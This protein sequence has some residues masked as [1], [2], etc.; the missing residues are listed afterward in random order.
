MSNKYFDYGT[1]TKPKFKRRKKEPKAKKVR[2]RKA[3]AR[4]GHAT[5]KRRKYNATFDYGASTLAAPVSA[6]AQKIAKIFV[7]H[8]G[9]LK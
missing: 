2:D 9:K 5:R 6:I 4:K 7:G 8:G 1:G 3:A